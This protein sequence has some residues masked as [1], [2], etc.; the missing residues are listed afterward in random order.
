METFSSSSDW[1]TRCTS[2][3]LSCAGVSSS[4][5][6]GWL[7][8]TTS[9][10]TLTSSRPSSR[11]AW[12]VTTSARWVVMTDARSTTVAPPSSAWWRIDAGIHLASRPKT[13]STVGVPG[14]APSMSPI[15]STVPAGRLAACDLD[16]EELD[17]VVVHG[18]VDVVAGAHRGYDDADVAG[19]LAAQRLDAVEQV[20]TGCRVDEVDHVGGQLEA[21][22]VDEDLGGQ[23]L[24]G[25]RR[26]RELGGGRGGLLGRVGHVRDPGRGEQHDAAGDEERDLGQSGDQAQREGREARRPAAASCWRRS[27]A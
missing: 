6:T 22:R 10:S 18:Q 12:L 5:T 19:H 15:A 21:E 24:G 25:V 13:G 9:V 8:L 26:G 14:R 17:R 2:P 20:A 16:A 23:H 27:G 3:R 7:R 1:R 4:T 11:A